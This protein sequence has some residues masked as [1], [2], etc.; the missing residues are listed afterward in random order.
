MTKLQ[1]IPL[2]LLAIGLV[3]LFALAATR[4]VWAQDGPDPQ[5]LQ[6]GAQLYAE[7]CAVCHG[8][9]GQGRV[10]A[11][12]AKNWP[13]IQPSLTIKN[14]I[15]NGVPGSPMPAW[16]QAKGG[17]LSESQIDALVVFLLSW[18]TNPDYP[19]TPQPTFTARPPITPIPAV[20]G[21]PNRG[22]V[23]FDA[24]CKVCHGENG[25]G[26]IGATLA[27]SWPGIRPDLSVKNTIINGV[28]GSPMP[29]WSV[30]KGGPLSE[31]EI[32]DLVSFILTLPDTTSAPEPLP[33]PVQ[34]G[35]L[36]AAAGIGV[37]IILFILVVSLILAAQKP[38]RGE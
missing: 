36:G 2:L 4:P 29:A 34:G 23:L 20:N 28:S 38:A 6:Q 37:T 32:D 27:K 24:N 25:A 26:R 5:L 22:A 3:W 16:S 31:A 10:G 15:N 9:D 12:L 14:V 11:T 1:R 13:S 19:T 21:D 30:E 7:N 18:E 33:T 8:P 17:P 35:G